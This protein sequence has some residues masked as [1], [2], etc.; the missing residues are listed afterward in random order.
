MYEKKEN[1][2]NKIK[3]HYNLKEDLSAMGQKSKN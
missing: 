3:F 2:E 1:D